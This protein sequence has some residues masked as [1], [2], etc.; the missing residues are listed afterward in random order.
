MTEKAKKNLIAAIGVATG[1]LSAISI[2]T[3]MSLYDKFFSRYEKPDYAI[4]PG[5]FCYDLIK[6]SIKREEIKYKS[7]D[8]T[9]TGFYYKAKKSKGLVVIAHG[10]H[11]GADDY[12]PIIMF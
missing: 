4:K 10:I 6:D 2:A 3:H 7:D 12:I 11:S 1:S 9:L 5:L 8:V